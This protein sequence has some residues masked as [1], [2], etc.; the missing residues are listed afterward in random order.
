MSRL[1]FPRLTTGG[2]AGVEGRVVPDGDFTTICGLRA[3]PSRLTRKGEA[4][5]SSCAISRVA[6]LCPLPPGVNVMVNVRE[7]VVSPD[8]AAIVAGAVM[9]PTTN[10]ELCWPV[11]VMELRVRVRSPPFSM[12]KVNAWDEM[13][14]PRFTSGGVPAF[15]AIISLPGSLTTMRGPLAAAESG[16]TKGGLLLSS[17]RI[18]SVVV[19]SPVAEGVK[20]TLKS[21]DPLMPVALAAMV[22]G[23]SVTVKSLPAVVVIPVMARGWSPVFTTRNRL[24]AEDPTAVPGS[25]T[26]AVS[27]THLTLPTIYSV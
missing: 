25:V 16:T 9:P 4:S 26:M 12:V 3:A 23:I 14:L 24:V 5:E 27:Y 7:C 6:V 11:V 2:F 10:S 19:R 1:V 8:A 21:A 17:W 22:A 20:L 15:G 18:S 13:T